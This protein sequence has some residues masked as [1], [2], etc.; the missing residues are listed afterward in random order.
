MTANDD[1]LNHQALDAHEWRGLQELA[2]ALGDFEPLAKRV[3]L[4]QVVVDRLVGLGLAEAG[5]P[6]KPYL[7]RGFDIGYRLTEL[8]WKVLDRGRSPK[9]R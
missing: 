9:P 5:P 7:A 2:K 4:G 6:P 1:L 8:G 3:R